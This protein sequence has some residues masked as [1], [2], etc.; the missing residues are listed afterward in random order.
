VGTTSFE[1]KANSKPQTK[2]QGNPKDKRKSW[3]SPKLFTFHQAIK[4]KGG[5]WV[6]KARKISE[7]QGER[8]VP[9]KVT[10]HGTAQKKETTNLKSKGR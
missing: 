1:K 8:R 5:G 6:T 4:A 2:I 7:T 9:A 3:S 10:H